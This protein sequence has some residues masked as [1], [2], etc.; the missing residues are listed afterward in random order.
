MSYKNFSTVQNKIFLKKLSSARLLQHFLLIELPDLS[1]HKNKL[2]IVNMLPS[3]DNNRG[4]A[5]VKRAVDSRTNLSPFTECVIEA[6]EIR[7]T[8]NK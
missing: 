5:A 6:L 1:K 7:I 4:M 3:I 2:I 8:I